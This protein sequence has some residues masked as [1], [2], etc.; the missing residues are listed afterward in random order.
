MRFLIKKVIPCLGVSAIASSLLHPGRAQARE[1][2][3]HTLDVAALLPNDVPSELPS[4]AQFPDLAKMLPALMDQHFGVG[5]YQRSADSEVR[6]VSEALEIAPEKC[7]RDAAKWK[8]VAIRLD[9]FASVAF[10]DAQFLDHRALNQ[11]L[12]QHR[13]VPQIRLTLQP[14]CYS[15][16]YA[17]TTTDSAMHFVFNVFG[18]KLDSSMH[19]TLWKQ[20][21]DSIVS[22][23]NL[24]QR[25]DSVRNAE[26]SYL[27]WISHPERDKD[28]KSIVD[29][30]LELHAQRQKQAPESSTQFDKHRTEVES[31][32]GLISRSEEGKPLVP[33]S[34]PLFRT[35]D[36]P[37]WTIFREKM[38]PLLSANNLHQVRLMSAGFG[39]LFW[40]FSISEPQ[41]KGNKL[42]HIPVTLYETSPTLGLPIEALSIGKYDFLP[43]M[44]RESFKKLQPHSQKVVGRNNVLFDVQEPTE[45]AFRAVRMEDILVNPATSH[46]STQSCLNCHASQERATMAKR[47]ANGSSP[48]E[49]GYFFRA[50][51]YF[52]SLPMMNR[53]F[54]AETSFTVS[55]VKTYLEQFHSSTKEN[56]QGISQ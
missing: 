52:S 44:R 33:V 30:I 46:S 31:E 2:S 35:S 43:V 56:K 9:P 19:S 24:L 14:F 49:F 15:D 41:M 53:R 55:Q 16:A 26:L 13:R 40:I 12:L 8:I 37:G 32:I 25:R 4:L 45:N 1:I 17:G 18:N 20:M 5:A 48:R 11:S 39:Q 23:E 3:L 38:I 28:I 29:L 47:V 36:A 27:K 42:S 22:E 21:R 10:G 51:G 7:L 6:P 50:F 34:H 54:L